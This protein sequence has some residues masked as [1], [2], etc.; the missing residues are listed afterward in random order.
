M[1]SE[2]SRSLQR[3]SM[4]RL[5]GSARHEYPRPPS[6]HDPTRHH[7]VCR[8]DVDLRCGMGKQVETYVRICAPIFLAVVVLMLISPKK[9]DHGNHVHGLAPTRP[10]H[11]CIVG[12]LCRKATRRKDQ[13]CCRRR[14]APHGGEWK[15]RA[16]RS[17]P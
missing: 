3:A 16:T 17:K 7:L 1:E 9:S 15:A 8:C 5:W 6:Y 14:D 4:G 2:S 11:V 12:D 10:D 13:A